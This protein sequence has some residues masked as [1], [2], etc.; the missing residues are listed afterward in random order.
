ME[1]SISI[2]IA[3]SGRVE[4]IRRL[5]ESIYRTEGRDRIKPEIVIANNAGS[6]TI[7]ESVRSL[8]REFDGRDGVRCRQVREPL[9]GK[10]R[11]QNRAITEAQGSVLAFFDDDVEVAPDWLTVAVEFFRRKDFDAMQGPILVPPEMEANQ[12]FLQA[13]QK[14]RTLSLVKY[15]SDLTEINTL[16][17]ANMA[18]RREVF[19]RIGLF[20]E[21]LGPGRS[22][23]S[24][25]VEFAQRLI[26]DGGRIG[27]EPKA[28]VYHEVDWSRFTEKFFRLRHE[29][30]GRSRFVYKKQSLASIIAN[31]M[32]SMWSFGWYSLVGDVRK[33]Y[34]AKGRYYHYRAM[35]QEKMKRATGSQG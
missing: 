28:I 33:Q 20:N 5:L 14:Y 34:R 22:G 21:A 32:R 13:Q 7:A 10:S 30:Q 11:A 8:T 19:P 12:E 1:P 31:L 29:Q 16:T 9:T 3:S 24:E 4:K 15:P 2:I 17:G 26:G 35:L 18:F 27:Y 6:E 23:N 25:D